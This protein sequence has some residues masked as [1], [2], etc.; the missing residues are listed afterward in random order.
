MHH[1]DSTHA[2]RLAAYGSLA[3]RLSLLSDV[4][5]GDV[6]ASASAVVAGMGGRSGELDI[7]GTRVFV[8]RVPLTEAETRSENVR[9]TA[10]LFGLPMFYQ[11]G[12]G[13]AGFGAWRELAVSIMTTNWVLGR[14]YCDLGEESAGR[15]S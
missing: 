9:S 14:E 8:K 7:D 6:V 10:N 13:S 11:Y 3:T 15:T 1:P 5:L 2:A 12:V 4:R